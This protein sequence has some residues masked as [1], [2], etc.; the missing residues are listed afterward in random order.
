[1]RTAVVWDR[2][3]VSS[4][5]GDFL[6]LWREW[7]VPEGVRGVGL[8]QLVED[9]ADPLRKRYLD[10]VGEFGRQRISG[11]S[12]I[13]HLEIRPG[14]SAWWMSLLVEK[15]LLKSPQM[16]QAIKLFAFEE[17]L[18]GEG[19]RRVVA[20]TDDAELAE[21][22]RRFCKRASM[23]F[24]WRNSGQQAAVKTSLVRSVVR[25]F[26]YLAH[27]VLNRWPFRSR[28]TPWKPGGIFFLDYLLNV[29]PDAEG[30]VRFASHYWTLLVD[31]LRAA[32]CVTNWLHLS[33][34]SS[35]I[36][37][38]RKA[39]DLIAGF[40]RDGPATETHNALD[41]FLGFGVLA[42]T[43]RDYLKICFRTIRLPGLAKCHVPTGS[44]VD[45]A[46]L[47]GRDWTDSTCGKTA[48]WNM[49]SLNL[50]EEVLRDL[51]SQKCGVYLQENMGWERAFAYCWRKSGQ[52]KLIGFPHTF[53]RFWDLRYFSG[54]AEMSSLPRQLQ[55]DVLA[56]TGPWNRTNLLEGGYG[57]QDL[58]EVE[59]LRYLF[60]QEPRP[61]QV[62]AERRTLLVCGDILPSANHILLSWLEQV[63][64]R[65]DRDF[66]VV[67]KSH[68]ALRMDLSAYPGIRGELSDRPVRELA[69]GADHVLTSN[70]TSA[71]VDACGA[72]VR[73]I[74]VLDGT[75]L[76]F[77]PLRG[78]AG[79]HFVRS[80]EEL[81]QALEEDAVGAPVAAAAAFYLDPELPR[82][83]ALLEI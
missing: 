3:G 22:L 62:A 30:K 57:E 82:W 33:F 83:K 34:L 41:Q 13:E 36:P 32:G 75:T 58:A 18:Q 70:V 14:L 8:P 72:T 1:M 49:L 78:V 63:L 46:P 64:G 10:W 27:Y 61:P 76:N 44:A 56:T 48:M 6:V 77:S 11:K 60:L 4:E 19:I 15:S 66:H 43:I 69:S 54:P 12:L 16:T 20:H 71:A 73:I 29:G 21:C 7:V 45:L 79:V 25:A 9:R 28:R 24:E 74:Q 51:P 35:A 23:E 37:T 38:F 80:A 55:P 42:G 2:E 47:M 53:V 40:N 26:A 65:M 68:P 52:G 31:K 67:V 5:T 59:A 50:F 17:C 81:L 39:G